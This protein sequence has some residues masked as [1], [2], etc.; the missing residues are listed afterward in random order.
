MNIDSATMLATAI[1]LRILNINF[2]AQRHRV[3]LKILCRIAVRL[4][5]DLQRQFI[6]SPGMP[7]ILL[8]DPVIPVT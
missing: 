1:R 3:Q 5:L 4:R 8:E 7:A 2:F 6:D